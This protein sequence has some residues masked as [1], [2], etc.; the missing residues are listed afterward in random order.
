[1]K[2]LGSSKSKTTKEENSE[3]VLHSEVTEV[4]LI[5]FNVVNDDN[6][7]YSRAFYTFFPNRT[8]AQLLDILYKSVISLK[9]FSSEFLYF[10]V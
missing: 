4:V 8:F 6:Q 7:H 3:N 5:H 9:A 1:M 2:L 10:E